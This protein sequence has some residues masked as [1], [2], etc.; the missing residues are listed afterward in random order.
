[1]RI[2]EELNIIKNLLIK[3]GIKKNDK[4]ML[5]SSILPLLI[6]YKKNK[7]NFK[8]LDIINILIDLI[9]KNGTLLIPVFNW[10][11]C[12]G[13]DFHYKKTQ[14]LSGSLGN[15]VLK[16]KKFKRSKNPI[17]SFAVYGKDRDLICNM[18]H[19][20]CFSLSSPFGYMINKKGK[21][22]FMGIEYTGGY[23][24]VHVAEQQAKVKYRFNKK[25]SGYC[26]YRNKKKVK[27]TI[28]M[29]VRNLKLNIMTGID[30]KFKNILKKN[31][32]FKE[33][34]YKGIIFNIID[35]KISHE[36]MVKDLINQE[37]MIYQKK[38]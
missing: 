30:D 23:T 29:F 19:S 4:I 26:N 21:N 32:A 10:D 25:F 1:M 36:L 13:K 27:K 24:P 15:I 9:G 3:I 31:N 7:I 38:L 14:S 2:S 18:P 8:P 37:G 34:N 12:K 20:N 33:D 35:S 5:T 22:L 11:F 16:N 28:T 17:Y 6:K